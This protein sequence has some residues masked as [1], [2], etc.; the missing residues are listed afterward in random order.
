MEDT[1]RNRGASFHRVLD[2]VAEYPPTPAIPAAT[3]L[4]TEL[5]TTTTAF[6]TLAAEQDLAFGTVH[7]ATVDRKQLKADL[8][9]FLKRLGETAR[10]LDPAT[11]PGLAA[12]M[13]LGR[14]KSSYTALITRAR[15]FHSAL[16]PVKAAFVAYGFAETV[17]A[18]LQA[19]IT[20]MEGATGRKND[21][22]AI[23]I[24]GTAGLA[25]L[26]K[27][28]VATVRKLDAI[29]SNVYKDNAVKFAGWKAARRVERAPRHAVEPAP[30]PGGGTGSG[31]SG[32][33]TP[34]TGS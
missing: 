9:S 3:L 2:F 22:K 26:C 29:L 1:Q 23:H 30:A 6:D 25:A 10:V 21:G 27:S 19:L 20:A 13:R 4:I 18:D 33:S 15:A 34:P 5:T 28:G 11:H 8:V 7:G 16:V 31:G 14:A 24:G 17:D 32:G 12:E